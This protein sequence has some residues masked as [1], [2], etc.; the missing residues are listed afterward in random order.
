MESDQVNPVPVPPLGLKAWLPRGGTL[1]VAGA[2]TTGAST[3]VAGDVVVVAER[4]FPVLPA[5]PLAVAVKVTLPAPEV[6]QLKVYPTVEPAV[7]VDAP[8]DAA[9]Q[10]AEAVPLTVVTLGA[11]V[12]DV[13]EAPPPA[14]VFRTFA[15]RETTCPALTVPGGCAANVTESAAGA[16]TVVAGELVAAAVSAFPLFAA[17]PFTVATM[18]SV[19]VVSGVQVKP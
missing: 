4:G 7:M 9:P 15:V 12:T 13:A 5:V 10:V 11:M 19:P 18:E 1:A 3:L 14:A 6:V 8:G 17:V 16:W 2:M